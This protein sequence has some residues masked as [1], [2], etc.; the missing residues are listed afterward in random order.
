MQSLTSKEKSIT[1]NA[2]SIYTYITKNISYDFE[3]A[4]E[5]GSLTRKGV[6]QTLKDKKGLC[7]DFT[8]LFI[9]LARS[10]GIPARE[11]DGYAY[12]KD[13]SATPTLQTNLLHSWVQYYNPQLGWVSVDP[14]WGATSGLDYFSKLDNN[15]LAFA[16]K[17]A[18]SQ[19][20]QPATKFKVDFS[21]DDYFNHNSLFDLE[22]L[23]QDGN[24]T[25]N[26]VF[27]G[28]IVA[29]LGL[30]TIL[31]LLKVHSKRRYK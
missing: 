6:L 31:V 19:N 26:P 25:P 12:T 30:C 1:Q 8:D 5:G 3:K 22:N 24:F 16:I 13:F 15:H 18:D 7:L 11:V 10:A 17:G 27:T 23:P 9:A 21:K 29:G 2:L 20:P 14:T 28:V 4:R